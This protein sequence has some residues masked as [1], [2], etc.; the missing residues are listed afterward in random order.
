MQL[1]RVKNACNKRNAEL[2]EKLTKHC[3]GARFF[4]VGSCNK[5]QNSSKNQRKI[6]CFLGRRFYKDFEIVGGW[7]SEAKIL[8]FRIFGDAFR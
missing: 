3:V 4:D 7:F 5:H 6:A 1:G 8:D 2:C